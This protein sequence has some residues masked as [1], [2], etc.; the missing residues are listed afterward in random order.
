MA[1]RR[2]SLVTFEAYHGHHLARATEQEQ[3]QWITDHMK[4][5]LNE[6][7][8]TSKLL[9][10]T[11]HRS[12]EQPS[13]QVFSSVL[14]QVC[15]SSTTLIKGTQPFT[16][17]PDRYL[18]RLEVVAWASTEDLV[19]LE[20]AAKRRLHGLNSRPLYMV[21]SK[22]FESMMNRCNPWQ[23]LCML[24]S[25]STYELLQEESGQLES[26][27]DAALCLGFDV[28][29][30]STETQA[31]ENAD[32]IEAAHERAFHVFQSM[33]EIDAL[34]APVLTDQQLEAFAKSGDKLGSPVPRNWPEEIHGQSLRQYL[35][36]L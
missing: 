33:E 10:T 20:A 4:R 11:V 19:E 13:F 15:D 5:L 16:V 6:E 29:Y 23:Y 3:L 28:V 18:T 7:L 35:R 21:L 26:E 36:L 17:H 9:P 31:R 34:L 24:M 1:N 30:G 2:I 22:P 12:L 14:L 32:L 8:L 25:K 27:L